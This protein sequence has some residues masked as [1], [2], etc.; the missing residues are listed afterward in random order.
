MIITGKQAS[1]CTQK[2]RHL[3]G[4]DTGHYT[5]VALSGDR[6]RMKGGRAG[7]LEDGKQEVFGWVFW[8]PNKN[9]CRIGKE[10]F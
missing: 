9:I 6:W 7:G 4:S 3:F 1:I 8:S 2:K 5:S 10:Q